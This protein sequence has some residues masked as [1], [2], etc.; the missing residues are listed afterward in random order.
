M[1]CPGSWGV[2]PGGSGIFSLL[3]TPPT[4]LTTY[5]DTT[6]TASTA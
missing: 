5:I 4:N 1:N 6:P 3:A 2:P